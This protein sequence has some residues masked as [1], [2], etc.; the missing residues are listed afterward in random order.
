MIRSLVLVAVVVAG[1]GRADQ[2]SCDARVARMSAHLAAPR[3]PAELARVSKR[4]AQAVAE[5][6]AAAPE[7]RGVTAAGALVPLLA[8][9]PAAAK[10]MAG[11]ADI[12]GGPKDAYLRAQLPP[13]FLTCRCAAPPEDAGALVELWFSTWR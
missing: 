8:P 9:C 11:V 5:V 13:A 12:E 7:Q 3:A 2:P 10:V 4:L 1:C 6:A